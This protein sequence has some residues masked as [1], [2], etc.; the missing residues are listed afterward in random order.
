MASGTH[1]STRG[2]ELLV[3]YAE[4]AVERAPTIVA[5]VVAACVMA[6]WTIFF[7]RLEF[8]EMAGLPVRTR[9]TLALLLV[10]AAISFA[11]MIAGL[12][13]NVA[14]LAIFLGG[15]CWVSPSRPPAPKRINPKKK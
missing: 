8:S 14:L 3:K 11:S 15:Y 4:A 5:G 13:A 9:L 10:G 6:A 12:G 2:S 1:D 7:F